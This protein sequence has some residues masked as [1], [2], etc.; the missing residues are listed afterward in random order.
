[1]LIS[2]VFLAVCCRFDYLL[3]WTESCTWGTFLTRSQL[4][5]CMISLGNMDQYAKS[6]RKLYTDCSSCIRSRATHNSH[7][8]IRLFSAILKLKWVQKM[9]TWIPSPSFFG[10]AC[11][12]ISTTHIGESGRLISTEFNLLKKTGRCGFSLNWD[13]RTTLPERERPNIIFLDCIC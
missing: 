13:S 2:C 4:R 7:Q 3:R 1:M 5:K 10:G 6:E 11:Y 12:E 9:S 8:C